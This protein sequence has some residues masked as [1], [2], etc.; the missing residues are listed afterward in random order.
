[1]SIELILGGARS[2][3]SR[4]AQ[5]LAEADAGTLIFVA[6]AEPFDD[7][8]ADRVARHRADRGDRWRTVEAPID[9]AA[10]I[11]GTGAD[12]AT[13]LVDCVTV[14]L[15]NLMHHQ[16]DIDAA[17]DALLNALAAAPGRII[18]VANEVGLALVPETPMGRR[19]RDLAGTLNQRLAACAGRVTLVVAGLPM[20]L[21]G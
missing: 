12:D 13:L 17:V 14:W 20:V 4:H 16:R 15:G 5:A 19:F 21:K 9:L 11:G 1:M 2:G 6:T 18:V 3:K 10:A 7:E 8:M